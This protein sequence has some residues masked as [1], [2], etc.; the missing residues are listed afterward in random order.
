MK[1]IHWYVSIGLAGCRQRDSFEIEENATEEE[2]EEAIRSIAFDYIE[3]G[4]EHE[5]R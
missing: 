1:T 2:I 4:Q 3:W 5:R